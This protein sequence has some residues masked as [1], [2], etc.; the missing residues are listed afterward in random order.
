MGFQE[1]Q[2]DF[3]KAYGGAGAN[4]WFELDRK[5]VLEGVTNQW[6]CQKGDFD[7][8]DRAIAE[9]RIECDDTSNLPACS[10]WKFVKNFHY[11]FLLALN[12]VVYLL[13]GQ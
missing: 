13:F 12:F 2:I 1:E 7:D 5:C 10:D 3:I 6:L 11:Q 8:A 4:D 9:Y